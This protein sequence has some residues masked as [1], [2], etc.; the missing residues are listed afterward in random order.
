MKYAD[1]QRVGDGS[2]SSRDADMMEFDKVPLDGAGVRSDTQVS[3]TCDWP[4]R[5]C[6]PSPQPST[7]IPLKLGR[8]DTTTS[9]YPQEPGARSSDAE[10]FSMNVTLRRRGGVDFSEAVSV[11]FIPR[12]SDYP[13]DL[14]RSLFPSKREISANAAR[15]MLEFASEEFD[16]RRVVEDEA[17]YIDSTGQRVHPIHLP[18]IWSSRQVPSPSVPNLPRPKAQR[19][20]HPSQHN[21]PNYHHL[22]PS[23]RNGSI[24]RPPT[25][26]PLLVDGIQM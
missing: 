19:P 10:K 26:A 8:G 17:M 23:F 21:Q 14:K 9:R 2:S 25:P 18:K 11:F 3:I 7:I 16:W 15:N 20:T 6:T 22:T 24:A 13:K 12:R 4:S 5:T 1:D